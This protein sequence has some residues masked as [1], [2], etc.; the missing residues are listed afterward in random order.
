MA[1]EKHLQENVLA[2]LC[3][4]LEYIQTLVVNI[5]TELFDNE[6]YRDI[7]DASLLYFKK[8]KKPIGIHLPDVFSKKI[9]DTKNRRQAEV[10]KETIIALKDLHDELDPRFVMGELNKFIKMQTTRLALKQ[11]V[12]LYQRGDIDAI[13]DLLEERRTKTIDAFD[14][15]LMFAKDMNRT[16]SFLNYEEELFSSGIKELDELGISPA[17]QELFVDVG[18]PNTGKTMGLIHKGKMNLLMRETVVHVSLEMSEKKCSMRYVQ[19]LLAMAKTRRDMRM[20]RLDTDRNGIVSN[21]SISAILEG[22]STLQDENARGKIEKKLLKL[23]R[24]KLVIKTFPTGMLSID[25]LRAYIY[26]LRAYCNIH[27]TVLIIDYADLMSLDAKNLR[28]ETGQIYQKLRGIAVENDFAVVTASQAN[29]VGENVVT[30]TRK[31]LAEDFSKV[32]IADNVITYNQTPYEYKLG[33]ARLYV[34]K[35]RNDRKGDS[36][37]ISQNYNM[38]QYCLQSA[39]LRGDYFDALETKFADVVK[40]TTTF[41]PSNNKVRKRLSR[42]METDDSDEENSEVIV[43]P[44]K[45]KYNKVIKQRGN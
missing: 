30:L 31:H 32:A 45:L 17:R 1:A 42:A 44:K 37:L 28:V 34:D 9:N 43:E 6:V 33:L 14:P 15:G 38:S 19:T 2:M 35:A 18:L 21:M 4:N 7:A 25:M 10:Y 24:P 22:Y 5:S 27:P 40:N 26:N 3:H 29:R 11:A 20:I 8:Y 36:I 41:N 13:D 39:Y 23:R 12:E 16:L